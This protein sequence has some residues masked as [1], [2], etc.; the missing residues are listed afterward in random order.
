MAPAVLF[1][2]LLLHAAGGQCPASVLL[3]G[4]SANVSFCEGTRYIAPAG[5]CNVTLNL[6]GGG[7]GAG[8]GSNGAGGGGASFT[9][10]F[11]AGGG[12]PL[13]A[14]LGGGGMPA[15]GAPPTW[16]PG[17]GGSAAGGGATAL[18]F[19]NGSLLAVAGGGGGGGGNVSYVQDIYAFFPVGGG[20]GG[21]PHGNGTNGTG[22]FP[23]PA[24]GGTQEGGGANATTRGSWPTFGAS[25]VA[26]RMSAPGGAPPRGAGGVGACKSALLSHGG[27]VEQ[28]VAGGGGWS[29]GGNGCRANANLASLTTTVLLGTSFLVNGGGGGG[30]WGGGG[31]GAFCGTTFPDCG[32]GGGG[33]SWVNASAGVVWT[34]AFSAQGKGTRASPQGGRGGVILLACAP[35][36]PSPSQ[37][38]SRS[39][40]PSATP[41]PLPAEPGAIAPFAGLASDG[42]LPAL[43]PATG[44][45]ISVLADGAGGFWYGFTTCVRYV[46]PARV[47]TPFAGACGGAASSTGDGGPALAATLNAPTALAANASGLFVGDGNAFPAA[48]A[49]ASGTARLRF[50]DFSSRRIFTVAGNGTGYR[51]SAVALGVG[52][53]G[54]TGV[55]AA[56]TPLSSVTGLAWAAG[57]GGLLVVADGAGC[58]MWAFSPAAGTLA[59]LAGLSGAAP[60]LVGPI[61]NGGPPLA[62]ALAPAALAVA[63]PN[64][65]WP[66]AVV[67][68]E[69][70]P[71]RT[72]RA[73]LANGTVVAVAGAAGSTPLSPFMPAAGTP[74]FSAAGLEVRGLAFSGAGLLHMSVYVAYGGVMVLNTAA[75]GWPLQRVA[76]GAANPAA[77]AV[78]GAPGWA[79]ATSRWHYNPAGLSFDASWSGL[80]VADNI[81]GTITGVAL[82]NGSAATLAGTGS[83]PPFVVGAAGGA[84]A[85]RSAPL[86]LLPMDAGGGLWAGDGLF[87]RALGPSG[88][89]LNAW[90]GQNFLGLVG[91]TTDWEP[92]AQTYLGSVRGLAPDGAGGYYVAAHGVPTGANQT[93]F[94]RVFA[95]GTAALW[96]GRTTLPCGGL[97]PGSAA[98]PPRKATGFSAGALALARDNWGNLYVAE[99]GAHVVRRIDNSSAG[100]VRVVAGA[101]GVAGYG[102]DGGLGTAALLNAPGGLALYGGALYI[103]ETAGQRVRLLAIATGIITTVAGTGST[104]SAG[105]NVPG[106]GSAIWSPQG[107]AVDACGALFFADT[108]PNCLVRKLFPNGTMRIAAGVRL[109]CGGA[110]GAGGPATGAA[111][112]NPVAVAVDTLAGS[113]SPSL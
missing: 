70:S 59:L 51:G 65:A 100:L 34:G 79:P 93:A 98:A 104:G 25:A 42:P 107:A 32:G 94:F 17:G 30:G 9:V 27:S 77:L 6:T 64:S 75:P 78:L 16:V 49:S 40:S 68:A 108:S 99:S 7:G 111:L 54:L 88:A 22:G 73:L 87:L 41:P 20:D 109:S 71:L 35:P 60:T 96:V 45:I 89:S 38:P 53:D 91:V 46:S 62:A 48:V 105:D 23:T 95:N 19:A 69:P 58:R 55:R 1:L 82:G 113:L 39:P 44:S 72:L 61:G 31:G 110:L 43:V 29:P 56:A 8:S 90:A 97:P 10:R 33:S 24:Q 2:F 14:V 80:L 4:A 84:I 52:A 102:G 76:G 112:S 106:V 21:P 81:G 74:S 11:W 12:A 15:P 66:G 36:S 86:A 5:G 37:T 28:S 13:V 83:F 85:L 57:S 92:A 50:V 47:S 101:C 18:M 67:W 26:A 3:T 103:V 63:P